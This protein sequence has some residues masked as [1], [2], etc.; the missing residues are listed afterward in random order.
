MRAR[1]SF[2]LVENCIARYLMVGSIQVNLCLR[3]AAETAVTPTNFNVSL[4]G[5]NAPV[6]EACNLR[7]PPNDWLTS[8][9]V[10]LD[11]ERSKD[12]V[13][14]PVPWCI[15]TQAQYSYTIYSEDEIGCTGQAEKSP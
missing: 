5:Q 10:G 1:P 11:R 4:H 9:G 2:P 13:P 12:K 6:N 7:P 14:F 15:N 3:V 8:I